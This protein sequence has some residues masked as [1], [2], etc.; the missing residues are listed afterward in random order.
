MPVKIGNFTMTGHQGHMMEELRAQVATGVSDPVLKPR[1]GKVYKLPTVLIRR[2]RPPRPASAPA[3][4]H[5]ESSNRLHIYPKWKGEDRFI[6]SLDDDNMVVRQ[7]AAVQA[8][9]HG[10]PEQNCFHAA[11]RREKSGTGSRIHTQSLASLTEA[12]RLD[13]HAH[14]NAELLASMTPE[15][16]AI[17]LHKT[18]LRSI[19][20]LK[21]QSC[22]SG[23][24]T[25]L[26]DLKR[27]LDALGIRVGYLSGPA[28]LVSDLRIPVKI[29]NKKFI[30]GV[31]RYL[32]FFF[33]VPLGGWLFSGKIV[34]HFI[35]ETMA[36]KV[37]K[38]NINIAFPGS[39]YSLNRPS[40]N[41]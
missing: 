3:S 6:V 32:G 31:G 39:R 38:G 18:G 10:V 33:P 41:Q 30:L 11:S 24:G 15:E 4:G 28:G 12:N 36:L 22:H 16:L 17:W 5:G 21:V 14:G 1:S 8:I 26:E 27:E 9:D 23:T 13:L 34:N 20:L 25:Y 40:A 19:G 7:G 35:P 37:V 29:G 2:D